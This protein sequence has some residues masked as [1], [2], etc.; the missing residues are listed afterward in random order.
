LTIIAP[1]ILSADFSSLK[2]AIKLIDSS[3][4]EWIHIDIMDGHFVPNLTIGPSVVKAIRPFTKKVFD[5]HLMID[6]P[7]KYAPEF[8]KAGADIITFHA[9]AVDDD[10]SVIHKIKKL[11]CQVGISI[12][13]LTP[14]SYIKNSLKH[15]D[16]L[17]IMTV[18]PGFGG[19]SFIKETLPKIKEA[20]E[21]IDTEKLSVN[22]Q[23][24]GGINFTTQKQ[25]LKAGANVFVAG[26]FVFKAADPVKTIKSL[27]NCK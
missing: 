1:S 10:F 4:A 21:Y 3:C 25:A 16:L 27:Q 9:E 20:R 15:V 22:L 26:H 6:D 11:G 18:E 19:Q 23:V 8:V 12:K 17:L 24:D 7:L 2:T 14:F 13:P 5:V